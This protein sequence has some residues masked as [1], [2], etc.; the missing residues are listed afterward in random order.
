[1]PMPNRV[2]QMAAVKDLT[3]TVAPAGGINY[4][5]LE[6]RIDDGQLSDALNFWYKDNLLR[7]RPGLMKQL[8]QTYGR[9][10]DVCPKDGSRLLLKRVSKNGVVSSEVYGMYIV[11]EQGVLRY[12][13]AVIEP[14]PA[15]A[16]YSFTSGKWVPTYLNFQ[17][18]QACLIASDASISSADD[19][20]DAYSVQAQS[21]YLL[22]PNGLFPGGDGFFEISPLAIIDLTLASNPV[23]PDVFIQSLATNLA[24]GLLGRQPYVPTIYTNMKPSGAGDALES[25]SLLT[26]TVKNE[27]YT[28]SSDTVYHLIDQNLETDGLYGFATV[29]YDDLHGNQLKWVCEPG[30]PALA[31]H[32][33]IATLDSAAGTITFSTALVDAA[34]SEAKSPNLVVEYSKFVYAN[35]SP[36]SKCTIASWFGGARQ[37]ET[38]GDCLFLSGNADEPTAVYWSAVG[39]MTY[40]PAD[41]VDYVGTPGDPITAFGKCFGNLVIFKRSSVYEK[42]FTWDSTSSK[43]YFPTYEVRI[44]VG[45]DCPGSVQL[46]SNH[47]VWLDSKLGIQTLLT[48]N[49]SSGST[50]IFTERAVLALSQNIN[51]A[52]LAE[53]VAD[54]QSAQSFDDGRYYWLFVGKHVYLW[55]YATTPFINLS[56]TSRLQDRLAW[57]VWS[58]PHDVSTVFLRDTAVWVVAAEDNAFYAFDSTAAL[59]EG[60]TWFEAYLITKGYDFGASNLLKQMYFTAFTLANKDTVSVGLSVIDDQDTSSREE[61]LDGHDT[62]TVSAVSYWEKSSFTRAIKLKI[63]RPPDEKGSFAVAQIEL[64]AK[65][66]RAA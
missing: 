48:T 66:G 26:P 59:D 49:T 53:T 41:N 60:G 63:Q 43:Q 47:L 36:V 38:S 29:T 9:I 40:W 8:T 65:L 31:D 52:L 61:V 15:E 19:G 30:Q 57:Y 56:D 35:P 42:G 32:G 50:N 46:V 45:C 34:S 5:R 13:G 62:E 21:V 7:M 12:D 24:S 10:L 39:D 51:K 1:M 17:F 33:I 6:N 14:V 23:Y 22:A 27:F 58:I 11:T 44:G 20:S 37:G 28:N 55:D 2:P 3:L 4:S 16:Q 18:K 25:R 64:R 54:L